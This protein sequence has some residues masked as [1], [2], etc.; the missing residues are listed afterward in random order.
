MISRNRN[1]F[2][3]LTFKTN[4]GPKCQK[5]SR[6]SR[7]KRFHFLGSLAKPFFKLLFFFTFESPAPTNVRKKAPS[8]FF[9]S[10][11]D[12][13]LNY[14]SSRTPREGEISWQVLHG[15]M[16]ND[17]EDFDGAGGRASRREAGEGNE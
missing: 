7:S 16:N 8:V 5:H 11:S 1:V 2:L 17:S 6:T 3:W 12:L 9:D 15:L 10:A 14:Y 4:N 13:C